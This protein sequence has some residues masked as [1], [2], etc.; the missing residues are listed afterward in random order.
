MKR[1]STCGWKI[2][3]Q[4]PAGHGTD[5]YTVLHAN[6][7]GGIIKVERMNGGVG[8]IPGNWITGVDGYRG[9]GDP[10]TRQGISKTS[11]R[12][13]NSNRG[14]SGLQERDG[15]KGKQEG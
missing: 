2:D 12:V 11:S 5:N 3:D 7:P 10:R 8:V 14:A 4:L 15:S 13:K 6:D 1:I 9:K